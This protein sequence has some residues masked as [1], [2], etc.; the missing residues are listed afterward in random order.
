MGFLLRK[1]INMAS[2]S[3]DVKQYTAPP[4]PPSKSETPCTHIDIVQSAAGLTSTQENRCLDLEWR[5]RTDWLFGTVKG[6]T[7]WV[8]KAGGEEFRAALKDGRHG[9]RGCGGG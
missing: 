2:V 7:R 3:L 5:E 4:S 1:A 8:G 6:R 9:W